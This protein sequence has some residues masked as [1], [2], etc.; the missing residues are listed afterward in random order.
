MSVGV[1][2]VFVAGLAVGYTFHAF[3]ISKKGERVK[4]REI[5]GEEGMGSGRE[6]GEGGKVRK[7]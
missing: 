5:W 2:Y 3:V 6:E 1:I 7:G 4:D